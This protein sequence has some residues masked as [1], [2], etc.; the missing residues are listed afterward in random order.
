MSGSLRLLGLPA[1]DFVLLQGVLV[2]AEGLDL[3][4]LEREE[5]AVRRLEALELLGE[6]LEAESIVFI[7]LLLLEGLD[8]IK[9]HVQVGRLGVEVGGYLLSPLEALVGFDPQVEAAVLVAGPQSEV[10]EAT[11]VPDLGEGLLRGFVG[12]RFALLWGH[13]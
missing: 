9:I 3:V 11:H 4:H 7:L 13:L 10:P 1:L 8:D 5:A 12:H 6:L 2:D